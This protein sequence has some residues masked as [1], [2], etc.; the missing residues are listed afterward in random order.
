MQTDAA[1]D[2]V[3][4]RI[5]HRDRLK[6][7][8]FSPY[9][10]RFQ[11]S[12][13]IQEL[14]L[15]YNTLEGEDAGTEVVS[16]AGRLMAFRGHG[17]AA[18]ADLVDV[19]GKIQ[20]H[21]KSDILGEKY[22]CVEW[23]DLGDIIG[24]RGIIFRTKRGELTVKVKSFETLG[25]CLI[26]L[27]EKWHGLR[28]V[29]IRYRQRYLDLFV[30]P[31]I[32][33]LFVLRSRMISEIRKFLDSRGFLE[34]ET[35][36][37]APIAGGATARPFVT[38]HNALDID[39]Y[40][41]IATE[42]YLKR[43]IVGGLEKVYEIGRI[44]RNEGISTRHNP[45]FTMME[46]YQAYGDYNDMMELTESLISHL[47]EELLNT[48]EV[49]YGDK[50]INF[51]PPFARLGFAELLLRY[52]KINLSDLQSLDNARK[53]AERL[54][55][56]FAPGDDQSHLMEK[57]FEAVVEPFLEQP[58]FIIDYP[59]ELSPLAKRKDDDPSMVYRFELFIANSEIAN[60]FSELNDPEDQRKRFLEQMEKREKG[61]VEAHQMDEDYITALE[62]G[63]PPTGGLGIG[64]D[65]LTMLL[66]NRESIRDVIL[67]PLLKPRLE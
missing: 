44:F 64:I 66:T 6:G 65:R 40:L 29:E 45:E 51:K 47:V 16:I 19:S 38:H 62:Y 26:P 43:L 14:L 49:H 57:I 54:G 55:I 60:A 13:L 32:R 53:T 17:K 12:H 35:P 10:N 21:F 4:Q 18:F 20:I 1:T 67:F 22:E 24:V 48:Y 36:V 7:A 5:E 25:K 27:P 8:G 33:E 46:L 30:N 58:T 61:N 3:A 9:G 50:I 15:K 11:R 37:M 59:V 52:G 2:Q 28:D 23:L 39:L 41:R 31:E 56:S 63:M 42:L 34:V